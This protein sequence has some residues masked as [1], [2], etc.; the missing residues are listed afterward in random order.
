MP[1]AAAAFPPADPASVA[2]M[3][4][5]VRAAPCARAHSALRG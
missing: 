5:R 4:R 1:G 3:R 2:Q